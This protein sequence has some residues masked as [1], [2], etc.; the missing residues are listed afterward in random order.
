MEGSFLDSIIFPVS[1]LKAD[2]HAG[3][4]IQKVCDGRCLCV[5]FHG[6]QNN[7]YP[8]GHRQWLTTMTVVDL[9]RRG[10]L[11]LLPW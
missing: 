7:K 6:K 9:D 5:C 4:G 8:K 3:G 10:S 11:Y 2:P 1:R